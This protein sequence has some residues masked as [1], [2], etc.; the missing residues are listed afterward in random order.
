MFF[1]FKWNSH[2]PAGAIIF[3]NQCLL[4]KKE[5][6]MDEHCDKSKGPSKHILKG[7]YNS[8]NFSS[9]L[10]L[11]AFPLSTIANSKSPI[12]TP[13]ILF[14]FATWISLFD[15]K[16][17]MLWEKRFQPLNLKSTLKSSSVK[18]IHLYEYILIKYRRFY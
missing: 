18:F 2:L 3:T 6:L 12:F 13:L 15:T 10:I 8:V 17:F 16:D 7:N 1:F 11:F 4:L 9:S 5:S 14:I